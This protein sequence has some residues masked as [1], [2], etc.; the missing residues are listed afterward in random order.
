MQA[1]LRF[2]STLMAVAAEM[3]ESPDRELAAV[4]AEQHA[5]LAR[6][7]AKL[8]RELADEQIQ[9]APEDQPCAA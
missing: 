4:A 2:F 6:R 3:A 1:K 7:V 8:K 5:D 9:P